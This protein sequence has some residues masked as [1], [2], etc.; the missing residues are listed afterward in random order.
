VVGR[1]S[2]TAFSVSEM[3]ELRLPKQQHGYG[4]TTGEY[5]SGGRGD[6]CGN[7]GRQL[8]ET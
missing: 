3:G 7:H 2:A 8:E 4:H 6:W 1:D 5:S